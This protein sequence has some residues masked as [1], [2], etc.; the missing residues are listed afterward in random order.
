MTAGQQIGIGCMLGILAA[1]IV[2]L[3]G[4]FLALEKLIRK[5]T[6]KVNHY[7]NIIDLMNYRITLMGDKIERMDNAGRKDDDRQ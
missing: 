5:T 2:V 7:D 6:E 1:A 4:E 3:I